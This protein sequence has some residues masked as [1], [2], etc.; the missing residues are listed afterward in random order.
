MNAI[1]ERWIGSCRHEATDHI[2]IT[3]ERHLHLVVSEHAEHYNQHRPH[4][5]LRQRAPNLLTD[6][7]PPTATNNTHIHRRDRL[8]GPI[9]EYTQA[10]RG[11]TGFRHPQAPLSTTSSPTP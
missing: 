2:L 6:P 7:E 3:G 5:S 8:G 4:R 9:H 10:H 11:D 1:A